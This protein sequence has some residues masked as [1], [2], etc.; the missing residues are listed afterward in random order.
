MCRSNPAL[1][2]GR[3]SSQRPKNLGQIEADG[4]SQCHIPDMMTVGE[5]VEMSESVA[6]QASRQVVTEKSP[7]MKGGA[8]ARERV[9]RVV[10]L[11]VLALRW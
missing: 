5:L 3:R 10:L 1:P 8:A 4:S 7:S 6:V 9:R 2:K 11:D